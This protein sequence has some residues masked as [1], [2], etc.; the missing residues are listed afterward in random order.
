V[1]GTTTLTNAGQEDGFLATLTDAGTTSSFT[2]ARTIATSNSDAV[3]GISVNGPN[4]YISGS[5]G[6]GS[7]GLGSI[8]LANPAATNAAYFASFSSTALAT[9]PS[10]LAGSSLYPNPAAARTI[11]RLPAMPGAGTATLS[12]YDGLGRIA[13]KLAVAVPATGL[14]Q[15][16]ELGS[17]V[18]GIYLLHVQAGTASTKHRLVIE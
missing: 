3:S 15:E 12:L 16:I 17:L 8:T 7:V 10:T 18:S 1:L 13:K 4:V 11:L 9:T 14:V 5:I 6:Q 2:W